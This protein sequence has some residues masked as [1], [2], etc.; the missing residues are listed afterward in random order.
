M[1]SATPARPELAAHRVATTAPFAA[2]VQELSA[3]LGKKLTAYLAGVKDT[4]AIDRWIAGAEPYKGA[5]GRLRR[6]YVVALTLRESDHFRVVQAWFTGLNPELDDRAPI[7][8]LA[9]GTEDDARAVLGA[10]RA[11][12]AG[13]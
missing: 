11:F 4:R 1:L 12:R 7:R 2:L 3:T 8:L 13:G 9:E 5:D 6:A 10:A